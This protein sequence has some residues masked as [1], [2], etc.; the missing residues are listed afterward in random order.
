MDVPGA[1]VAGAA[2]IARRAQPLRRLPGV[3]EGDV[4]IA[5]AV[6][7]DLGMRLVVVDVALLVRHRHL[8]GHVVDL[9]LVDSGEFEEMRLGLFGEVEQRLGPG[10]AVFRFEF[11]GP[12]ALAGAELAAIAAR[13]A[14]A[15][16]MRFDQHDIAAGPGEVH[17]RRQAGEA[18]AN[19]DDVAPQVTVER[20]VFGPW[21]GRVLI[22]GAAGGDWGLVGHDARE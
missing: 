9:D 4:W 5:E 13:S 19:D 14:V 2:E 1:G 3:H 11:L 8:A 12:G 17:R 22:P 7:H 6:R 18:A 20:L 16:A 10:K 15:E 21:A